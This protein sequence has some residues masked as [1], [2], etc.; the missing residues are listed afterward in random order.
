LK[1]ANY[2]AGNGKKP[3]ICRR[4]REK[5]RNL[6]HATLHKELTGQS[7]M[8]QVSGFLRGEK[9]DICARQAKLNE[10]PPCSFV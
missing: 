3:E 2:V 9:I 7:F 4:R 1:A 6:S 8:Q 10:R 5:T